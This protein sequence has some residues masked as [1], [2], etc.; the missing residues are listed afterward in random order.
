MYP[1][2]EC[3]VV[4]GVVLALGF[5][6]FIAFSIYVIVEA[7]VTAVR[8]KCLAVASRIVLVTREKLE[9]AAQAVSHS[10]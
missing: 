5:S 3:L 6:L 2:L 7:T 10:Q 8:R 4:A 9:P 1:L